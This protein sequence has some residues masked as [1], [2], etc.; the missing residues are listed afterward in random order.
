ME[1]LGGVYK[2]VQTKR[3]EAP[4]DIPSSEVFLEGKLSLLGTMIVE[5]IPPESLMPCLFL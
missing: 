1:L 4:R 5:L 2:V 3:K